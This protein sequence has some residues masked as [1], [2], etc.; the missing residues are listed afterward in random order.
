M[1]NTANR[2]NIILPLLRSRKATIPLAALLLFGL[3]GGVRAQGMTFT[4]QGR[5]LDNG[6]NFTGTGQFKFALVTS[7][8]SSHQA[9]ATANLTGSFVTSYNLTYGGSGY[10]T[11]PAVHVTGGGGSGATATA[12]ISGGVV[13][14]IHPGNAGSGYSSPPT[15]TIDPPPDNTVYVTYWSNDGTSTAGSEPVAGVPLPVN[16]GLFTVA[17][18]DATLTNMQ[19]ISASVFTQPNLQLRIWFNDGVS[20]SAALSPVQNLTAAPYAVMAH[21]AS[22]LLGTLPAGQLSGTVGNSQL[23]SSSITVTRLP[24]GCCKTLR[25]P[26]PLAAA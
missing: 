20:G 3:A 6:T 25:S 24:M 14:A 19:A 12:T 18:G 15:V 4:Y 1:K 9:T 26:S 7:T 10:V 23:A 21:S 8:N 11:A 13:A 16:N 17:L 2:F 22:N 5:V